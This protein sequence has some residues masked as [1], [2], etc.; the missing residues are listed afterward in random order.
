MRVNLNRVKGSVTAEELR[1]QLGEHLIGAYPMAAKALEISMLDLQA[2]MKKGLVKPSELVP[3]LIAI[4]RKAAQK[5]LK[6]SLATFESYKTRFI[7]SA[8]EFANVIYRNGLENFARVGFTALK[9]WLTLL[10][11]VGREIGHI[12]RGLSDVLYTVQYIVAVTMDWM[13][14]LGWLNDK[15]DETEDSIISVGDVIGWAFGGLVIAKFG[16]GLWGLRSIF[17]K[18][19]VMLRGPAF[20]ASLASG[21]TAASATGGAAAGAT[22]AAGTVLGT[23][24]TTA[25]VSVWGYGIYKLAGKLGADDLGAKI[26]NTLYDMFGDDPQWAKD[27]KRKSQEQ[28]H[29]VKMQNMQSPQMVDVYKEGMIRRH[30][31]ELNVRMKGDVI[32]QHF[33]KQINIFP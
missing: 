9:Q 10:K 4:Y 12:F 21:I 6:E 7:N 28:E 22:A 14:Y 23:I 25:F 2:Q 13:T 15:T 24:F 32:D 8:Q 29:M 5:G 18:L 31:I 17:G 11:P 26:G 1:G 27:L 33:A 30:D 20:G 3:K 19:L 16:K